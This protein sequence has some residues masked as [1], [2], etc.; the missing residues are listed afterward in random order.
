VYDA[1]VSKRPYKEAL[2]HEE[3]VLTIKDGKGT[4]FDPVL[5]DVFCSISEEFAKIAER[6]KEQRYAQ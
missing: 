3:A 5:T 4:H 1:L 6:Y 2:T